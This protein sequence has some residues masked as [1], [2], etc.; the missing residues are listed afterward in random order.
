M[1]AFP[2]VRLLD[3]VLGIATARSELGGRCIRMPILAAV[4]LLAAGTFLQ[5][6]L[7]G[8]VFAVAALTLLPIAL[9]R[10]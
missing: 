7:A 1:Y 5:Q 2:P 4:F 3:F 9:A 8:T 6:A 10:G